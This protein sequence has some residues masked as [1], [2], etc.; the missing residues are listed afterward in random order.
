MVK[1]YDVAIIGAGAA[2][3]T[4]A[5]TAAGFSKSVVLIDKNLPGGEC[6]WSGCIPSKSLINIA[7]EVYHAKKYTPDLQVDTSVVL[8]EIQDVIQ[9]VYAGESPEVLKDA[10]ID[11][12]NSY[13]KFIEP[14]ALEVD[15]ERIEAKKI[16]LSTGSSPMVPPIEG[17]DQVSYL[18]N[19]TIFTQKTFPKT[20]TILGGGA[21][22][23]ELSQ[24]LNRL[25]V[26]V[27]LVEKFERILPKD[28]EELVLMI[29]QSLI[30]EGVTI[31][32]GA[33]AVR[34]EQNGEIIDL[35]IEKDGK[36]MTV[37]GEGLLVALGR[38]AN[39]NG[40]G[41]ETAGVEFDSKSIQV[42]EHLETTA[43]GIYAIGDV[44]GPYQLS[45]MANAQGILATQNAILPINRKMDY[46]HVTWCTY[47]DPELG[48]SGLSE[49]EARE[50]YGDSIRVYE[51][52]YADLDRANTKKDSIGKVKLILDKK[53][54]ILGA[55]I[56][57]D[58]AGEII[59]Q[60]QTIKTLKIN[61]GKLSGVIHPYPTYSEV[62]VKI[63][64]KV[65]VDNLLNQPVVKT[66]NKAKAGELPAKKIGIYGAATAT[67]LSIA[68]LVVHNNI[69]PKLG[70]KNGRLK[71]MPATPNAISSQTTEQD[72]HVPAW[73]YNG[74]KQRAKQSLLE[75]L[76]NYEGVKIQAMDE[77]YVRAIAISKPLRFKD[78]IEFYF[79][80]AAQRIEF[81]SASRAGHSDWGVNRKRY[82]EM[83]SRYFSILA[84]KQNS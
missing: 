50:K 52:E 12:I 82:D 53:G 39:V 69:K 4:A 31:H 36:E 7:K 3:L 13:A 38:Q 43:K 72:M 16:I 9:K 32:T 64:K 34:A 58:R 26:N 40:Y 71:E 74:N 83:R 28:E 80:D 10:G 1:K 78:D 76:E 15:N 46:E 24:A 59:S 73:P 45:H 79:N 6:T 70:V 5:F 11:F 75:M 48:R 84:H 49:E 81:R 8:A 67:G 42:D 18:T 54:Y 77:N 68:N 22:G 60:I 63:G 21:I 29:Q 30:D 44:V 25:G 47:T 35:T 37:S 66:F 51:H 41:L 62:L 14:H 19:E 56:L 33:T 57:G 27:T 17:L 20:M 61:M 23:V 55:S 2:G 65:F